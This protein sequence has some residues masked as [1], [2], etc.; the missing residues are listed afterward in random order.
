MKALFVALLALTVL[1]TAPAAAQTSPQPS[2][3][4]VL[5]SRLQAAGC[6]EAEGPSISDDD[7]EKAKHACPD[8]TPKLR[9]ETG[10]HL[11]AIKRIAV[12]AQCS[13]AVT[14]SDDKTIR[15]WSLADGK[16]LRTIRPPIGDGDG[17]KIYAV[18]LSP[19]GR[20]LAAG[21]S[22]A[23]YELD[24]TERITLFP[25]DGGAPRRLGALPEIV[26]S[27]AF[28]AD[29]RRL[30][31]VLGSGGLHVF[32]VA[33]G[34]EIFADTDYKDESYGLAFAADGSLYKS[35]DAGFLRAYDASLHLRKKVKAPGGDPQSLALSPNGT[36]L[37]VG[38]YNKSRVDLF[39]APG[40][41]FL[42]S[43]DATGV[44]NGDLSIVTWTSDGVL[45]AGGGYHNST[46]DRLVRSW[47]RQGEQR[48][49][50]LPI[51][52]NAIF[53]LK[54]CGAGLA[55]AS[56]DPSF[57]L[58]DEKGQAHV[59]GISAAPDMRG[60]LRQNFQISPD[61]RKIYFG[62]GVGDEEPVVMDLAKASLADA[63]RKPDKYLA[64]RTD[65][66]PVAHWEDD[67]APTF[68]GRK[69]A[70]EANEESRSVAVAHGGKGF[71]L[72]TE[73]QL[74]AYDAKGKPRGDCKGMTGTVWGV[75]LTQDDPY[76][77]RGRGR[78]HDPLVSRRRSHGT[79]R[80]VRRQT[81]Q[82]LGRLDAVGLLHRLGR[83]RGFD[84]LAH[85]SR[86]GA[87]G[88]ILSRLAISRPI[89]SSRHSPG[90]PDNA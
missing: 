74:R 67:L 6:L 85:Q 2:E 47:S 27:L 15:L 10:M 7:L 36:L 48:G 41:D 34:Q 61:G 54:A 56:A 39:S 42:K 72:G 52:K 87:G 35:S 43:A 70:L 50:D 55:F 71:F 1:A 17:G 22:D 9:I 21:G 30:A 82:A 49:A 33:G 77:R 62:L 86:L 3:R 32:D 23:E 78:R 24:Q 11:A 64:A 81:R 60:K 65:G 57:G 46:V 83:R 13:R 18:A 51:A 80:L 28:S 58:V 12:D 31:A 40:L 63:P 53:D 59:L 5:R 73:F 84:R 8:Q 16:L 26:N 89:L 76:S 37:A 90:D 29:G 19:D 25:L 68:G 75:D 38:Y 88:R 69:L 4:E 44:N 66:L 14:G 20:W 79:S 45:H